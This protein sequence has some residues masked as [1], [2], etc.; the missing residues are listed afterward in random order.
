[1]ANQTTEP[2]GPAQPKTEGAIAKAKAAADT[3][4]GWALLAPGEAGRALSAMSG[5]T[6]A[7]IAIA[8]GAVVLLSINVISSNIFR[9]ASTDLTAGGLYSISDSTRKV[10]STIGEP[11]DV[12]VYFSNK[13]GEAAPTYK[14]YF[15]RVRAL[16]ERYADMSSGQL[17]VAF[18]E[19]EPFS[20]AEDRAVAAG[21][22]GLRL[23]STGDQG[24]FGLVATNST[25]Q[26]EVVEFFSPER[27][28]YLEY[29]MTKLVHKLA[30][31]KKLVVGLISSIPLLG[32]QSRPR[33]PG[34]QP[35]QFP[36]WT[37]MTQ[38]ED[39]F[40]VRS[41]DLN[42]KKIPDDVD[43]VMIVQPS[44]LAPET[45]YAIDQFVLS[46]KAVLAFIDPVPEI[47]R[48]MKPSSGGGTLNPEMA[49]LL[50]AWGVEFDPK[51]VA[52]DVQIARRVQTADRNRPV[53]TE[54]IS[55]LSVKPPLINQ[56]D[57]VAGSV[58]VLNLASS[59]FVAPA[60]KAATKFEPLF[61]TTPAA[62][63]VDAAKFLAYR[64]D[65]VSLLR[66]YRAGSKALVL[67]ARITGN[68]KTAFPNGKPKPAKSD[69]NAD[70]KTPEKDAAKQPA[71]AG[72]AK[73]LKAGK[74]NA[75]VVADSDLLY[76]EFWVQMRELLG[77]RI[78]LPIAHNAVL[79]VNM[80]ENLS[81]GEALSGLRGRGVDERPFDVVQD[82][83]R[84]AER[85][86]RQK[87][88]TLV[89]KLTDLRGKLEKVQQRTKDGALI[90][91]DVDKKAVDEFR[92]EMVATR[93]ELRD[94]KHAMRA[95]IDSLEGWLKFIN[96]AGVP[97]AFGV[98]G[99][100]MAMMRRRRR[101]GK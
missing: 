84:D 78:S 37:V 83:R 62:M 42:A 48:M 32:G 60:D 53:V 93:K 100:V 85:R 15:E 87:E 45:A 41:I 76:D 44:G 13:L 71:A 88:D 90:L 69:D 25:D 77:Q 82:I 70:T 91:S 66:A 18:I 79:V 95:D 29:D 11:I 38:I 51:K 50:K 63:E 58:K 28:K 6:R 49:K 55:W 17:R 21:L 9:T 19:P 47:G 43:V 101:A 4:T 94:V 65:P 81:G 23:N 56:E 14:R 26:Q 5:A 86:F 54:Y 74:L 33:F 97:L 59:G 16:F 34:Q 8:L 30:A 27:E 46:G 68:V 92:G 99:I 61:Q 40:E 98:G 10:L 2:T 24:Y 3:L 7:W 31:P 36:K 52:G 89:K 96:I 39:F 20:D 22:R 73:Q 67:A 1:M 12:R 35:Q 80:L 64:P 72:D 75:I 57:V